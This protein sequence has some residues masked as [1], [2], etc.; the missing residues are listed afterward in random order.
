MRHI[1]L[2]LIAAF[3]LIGCEQESDEPTDKI[4]V[5]GQSVLVVSEGG[6][7]HHVANDKLYL[8]LNNT[9]IVLEQVL[10]VDFSRFLEDLLDTQNVTKEYTN[11]EGEFIHRQFD[12]ATWQEFDSDNGVELGAT[13]TVKFG[14][15]LEVNANGATILTV[16]IQKKPSSLGY[17]DVRVIDSYGYVNNDPST[18][19][20]NEGYIVW[21]ER[22]APG[23]WTPT[24]QVNFAWNGGTAVDCATVV[25]APGWNQLLTASFLATG[26]YSAENL[27]LNT[28]IGREDEVV[29]TIEADAYGGTPPLYVGS[30]INF[31]IVDVDGAI[32]PAGE[33][34]TSFDWDFGDSN[35]SSLE[36]PNHN[37]DTDG[38]YNVDCT[39]T[40]D[41]GTVTVSNSLTIT[42]DPAGS[43][44]L[45]TWS[46][47]GGSNQIT[48][49]FQ[50]PDSFTG[51]A[52]LDGNDTPDPNLVGIHASE[53]PTFGFT[54][55]QITQAVYNHDP[56]GG[57]PI[58]KRFDYTRNAGVNQGQ[59]TWKFW[60]RPGMGV[61][62]SDPETTPPE[63]APFTFNKP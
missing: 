13:I 36:E 26:S 10:L 20:T 43:I 23:G 53:D 28:R 30:N 55:L 32:P 52:G 47:D 38:S 24:D 46:Y 5:M 35:N 29:F 6:T 7:N 37:Y 58:E 61:Q 27:G 40:T 16:L 59:G 3:A 11:D 21:G 25:P 54:V 56:G 63:P 41:G 51:Y 57:A 4:P 12:G 49:T 1:L 39:I 17:G 15:W 8:E 60:W 44:Q 22:F 9:S 14:D 31:G 2:L 50:L 45:V 42:V 62:T 48:F 34:I 33:S 19:Q 18:F